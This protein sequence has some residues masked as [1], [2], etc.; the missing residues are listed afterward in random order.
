VASGPAT[1]KNP[2]SRSKFPPLRHTQ[3]SYLP[4]AEVAGLTRARGSQGDVV[5]PLAYTGLRFGEFIG[6]NVEDVDLE[7]RR[8]RVR[9][10]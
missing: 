7:A 6:L 9:G 4:T 5:S 10:P 1:G 2:A 8:I 3:H